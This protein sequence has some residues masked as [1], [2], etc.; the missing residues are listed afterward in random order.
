MFKKTTYLLL[1]T[2]ILSTASLAQKLQSK[3]FKSG[4]HLTYQASYNMSGVLATFA[5]VN[6]KVAT[7]N[8]SKNKYLHLKCTANTYAKWDNFFKI[9]DLYEAYVSPI[10]IKPSLYIRDNNENGTIRKEKYVYKGNTIQSSY[11]R[12]GASAVK[13][14]FTIPT[15]TRDIVSTLYF[16]RN[17]PIDKANKGDQKDFNIVFDRKTVAATLTFMGTETISTVLGN[18][19]CYKIGVSL[20]K[21]KILEGKSGNIIYITADQNKVPVLIKFSIPV[22]NGQLKLIKATNLKY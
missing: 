10:T 8:T 9:R 4:E 18:K 14:N 2:L 6:L 20:K 7:V 21:N 5:E 11:V 15:N 1:S 3:S 19:K 16:L 17:L 13:A 22:G 12:G